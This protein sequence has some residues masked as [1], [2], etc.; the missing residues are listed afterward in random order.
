VHDDEDPE[1]SILKARMVN[2]MKDEG[3]TVDDN[4]G[5]ADITK[6]AERTISAV[7]G[8]TVAFIAA[9][10]VTGVLTV[11]FVCASVAC[12]QQ[13]ECPPA[14]CGSETLLSSTGLLT[15]KE[16]SVLESRHVL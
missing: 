11:F 8:G 14:R 7:S 16:R 1:Y 12:K 3:L 10:E 6:A 5:L 9:V 2:K 4:F 13:S 15:G